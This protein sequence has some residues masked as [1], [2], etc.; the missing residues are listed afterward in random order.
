MKKYWEKKYG[1][2]SLGKKVP[3]KK[4]GKKKYGKKIRQK[5]VQTWNTM[6]R[7]KNR[8]FR[9]IWSEKLF[10]IGVNSA[11]RT[12]LT[13]IIWSSLSVTCERSFVSS[14]NSSPVSSTNKT[15]I[16]EILLNVALTKKKMIAAFHTILVICYIV[17]SLH[18]I[19]LTTTLFVNIKLFYT[20]SCRYIKICIIKV[21]TS[22]LHWIRGKGENI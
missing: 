13:T 5:L 6:K 10:N 21:S 15:D 19:A 11:I 9:R 3:E 20:W 2:K 1:K 4:Y 12:R 18:C 22:L 8:H 16:T 17:Q 14:G 7:C